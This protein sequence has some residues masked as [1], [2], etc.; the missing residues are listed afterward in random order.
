MLNLSRRGFAILAALFF[1]DLLLVL[2]LVLIV[3]IR[4]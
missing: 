3:L 4:G 1:A 2:A